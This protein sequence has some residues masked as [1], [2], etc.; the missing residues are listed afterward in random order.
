MPPGYIAKTALISSCITLLVVAGVA[1][2]L[3]HEAVTYIANALPETTIPT[4]V[5]PPV[6]E[7]STSIADMVERVNPAVVSIV[8]TKDVPVYEQ[9][10]EEIAPW[11]FWGGFSVP[12]LRENGTEEQ[13]VGGGSGFIVDAEGHIVTNRHVVAD[14]DA[15][16][17]VL[18]ND[19]TSH[20]VEVLAR[21]PQLDI[22]VLRFVTVPT[23]P[24]TFLSF[25]DSRTLRLGETVVAIGNALAEFRNSVSV[26]VV[27]GLS[28]SIVASDDSG[29]SEQLREVI[30]TD[31]AIN[32]GN[33]G[34]P[35]LTVSGTVIG[36][37]VA[38]S[39]GADNISFALPSELVAGVVESV[40]THGKI[41]RPYLGVRFTMITPRL[42]ELNNL[43][44]EY[45]ALIVRGETRDE[46]AVMPGSPAD[47]AGLRENDIIL[48]IDGEAL[49]DTDLATIL[50]RKSIGDVITLE[51]LS[52]GERRQI[53]VTLEAAP[54]AP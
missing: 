10:Y 15:R 43:T 53:T 47:R 24:L 13:E 31:A 29:R 26:G 49:K 22:A 41:V 19:G 28:R 40:K 3:R 46:L 52:Q 20:A 35:L 48:A 8:V 30:Q 4:D 7:L 16:Y 18:L 5:K 39:R 1:F 50:R 2:S 38:T 12:R 45:G 34:G 36:V 33:S 11:G 17:T 25:G 21:D 51:V 6:V 54:T 23:E 14:E 27:S 37:N 32:P 44:T 42:R 9:Y